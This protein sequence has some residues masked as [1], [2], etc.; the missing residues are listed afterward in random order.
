M[1]A[2]ENPDVCWY[3]FMVNVDGRLVYYGTDGK[4]TAGLGCAYTELPPAFQLTVF[5]PGFSPADWFPGSVMYQIFP[6]RFRR[7]SD[8][9]AQRG[10]SYHRLKGRC[11]Y[12][13][14]N[15]DDK[16][17]YRPVA[18]ENAYNPCD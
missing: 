18:G 15:W 16:P 5:D 10:L 8:D 2:P 17:L 13:H 14:K 12:E 3:Y 9:T 6:D 1:T 7:S 11:V 4:R